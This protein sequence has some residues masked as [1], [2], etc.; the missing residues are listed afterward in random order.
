MFHRLHIPIHNFASGSVVFSH[1]TIPPSAPLFLQK[2]FGAKR[3]MSHHDDLSSKLSIIVNKDV[4]P[5]LNCFHRKIGVNTCGKFGVKDLIYGEISYL[6]VE[7]C[8]NDET[9]CGQKAIHYNHIS[10]EEVIKKNWSYAVSGNFILY[11]VCGIVWGVILL[12][13]IFGVSKIIIYELS[14]F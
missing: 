4:K 9:K 3:M 2:C 7:N 8:R 14:R 10:D 5:C 13:I 11:S 6:S 12:D 1:T